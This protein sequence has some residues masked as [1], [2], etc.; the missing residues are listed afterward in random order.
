M[1]FRLK[2]RGSVCLR[3]PGQEV[4]KVTVDNVQV[5]ICPGRRSGKLSD[6]YNLFLRDKFLL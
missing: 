4:L 6:L 2:Q 1:G 3:H 5:L